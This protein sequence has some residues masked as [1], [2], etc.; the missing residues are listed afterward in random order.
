M[1]RIRPYG[2]PCGARTYP[3]PVPHL[4]RARAARRRDPGSSNVGD[5][6]GHPTGGCRFKRE[7]YAVRSTPRPR[8]ACTLDDVGGRV[9]SP[10]GDRS[11]VLLVGC[12]GC[13]PLWRSLRVAPLRTSCSVPSPAV[14]NDRIGAEPNFAPTAFSEVRASILRLHDS[15]PER[16]DR[17]QRRAEPWLDKN[18]K[19]GSASSSLEER[20]R[21]ALVRLRFPAEGSRL[22]GPLYAA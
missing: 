14:V 3:I 22:P 2:R 17:L 5:R 20:P 13:H 4:D 8:W 1:V 7:R 11:R 18:S 15:A 16:H 9:P 10:S 6:S 21:W 12:V 19:A